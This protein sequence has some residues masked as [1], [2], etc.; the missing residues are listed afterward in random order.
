M[1]K[2]KVARIGKRLEGE[3]KGRKNNK[4]A[5]GIRRRM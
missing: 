5:V 2:K 3:K 4:K 1:N